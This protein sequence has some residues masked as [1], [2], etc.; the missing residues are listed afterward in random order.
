MDIF[1]NQNILHQNRL[2]PRSTVIPSNVEDTFYYNKEKSDKIIMLTGEY[3]FRYDDGEWG[4]LTVPSMWQF[5]GYG[6]PRY[7]NVDY[8]FPFNP[9]YV[10]NHNH[11]GHYRKKFTVEEKSRRMILHFD[12]VDSA[13]V[14]RINGNYVGMSKGSRLAAEF[15]VAEFIGVGE[16]TIE[17]DVYAL[18]DGSYLEAQDMVLASG[19]FRDVYI[20]CMGAVGLWDYTVKPTLASVTLDLVFDYNA[21]GGYTTAVEIDGQILKKSTTSRMRFDFNIKNPKLWNA[22]TPNLYTLKI[23]VYKGEALVE[24]HSKKIGLREISISNSMLLINGTPVK[25]KGVNRHEYVPDNGR[26]IDYETTKKEL[27]LLKDF[28]CNAIRCSHYPNNPFFYELANEIGIY[29][30]DE[31]D[32]EAHGCVNTGDQGYISKDPAW[33]P[34][35]LDRQKRMYERDKNETCII[36][37]SVGNEA[38]KGENIDKCAEYLHSVE[39]K[40][41]VLY[42]QDDAQ[43]PKV[44][45]FRQVGYDIVASYEMRNHE[46]GTWFKNGMAP[47]IATEY[48]HAMGNSPGLLDKYWECIYKY[49]TMAGGFVWEF[50]NHGVKRGEDYLYG[51]DF[52]ENN[53]ALNFNLDGMCLSDGTPKPSMY[54]LRE[55]FSPAW[56][57]YD[58]GIVIRNTNDFRNLSYL[59]IEWSLLENFRKIDGG[60]VDN[61]NVPA[62][63]FAT[64]DLPY[65][66]PETISSGR[67]YYVNLDFY[68]GE[69]LVSSKQVTLPFAAA[70]KKFIKEKFGYTYE[71]GVIT[72]EDF[73]VKF[74]KGV[75]TKFLY[76]GKDLISSPMAFSFY[77]K[78]IDNDGIKGKRE[79]HISAWQKALLCEYEFFSENE[80]FEIK[81]DELVLKYSG[82]ILPE[83]RFVGFL[84]ELEYHI[85]RGG[86]I[87]VDIKCKPYGAMPEVLPRI[88]V[89]FE[90][91]K[92][93]NKAIWFGRGE[94]ENY[95]DRKFSAKFGLYELSV[96]DMSFHYDR[97]QDNGNRC[98]T[99]F[100]ALAD[101][102]DVGILVVGAEKF[103]FAATDYTMDA[104]VKAEHRSELVKADNNYLY[105]N[106]RTRGIC[107]ASCG[108]EPDYDNELRPHEFEFAFTVM[109][110]TGVEDAERAAEFDYG[111]STKRFS[112]RYSYTPIQMVRENFES[113]D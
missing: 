90:T 95:D 50:K 64:L 4:K 31:C 12:G 96:P 16:N 42:P 58:N 113:K 53:H 41:P 60:R 24:V 92:K 108:P 89:V 67:K 17:I 1:Q 29:V 13:F 77:R 44:T 52:G 30:M 79:K 32:L 82:K 21:D 71:N 91:D 33:L 18:N 25:L 49:H 83:A 36:I 10:G 3:D 23:S 102:S 62:G 27:L 20:I 34:A 51:S 26:A 93:Y 59:T 104:L 88:G 103:S 110:F 19:I 87:T 7:T 47:I 85:C 14:V 69:K 74:E 106:Y 81:E 45:D 54:E 48:A 11:V 73:C 43:D 61:I 22:E 101:D 56:V 107:S 28:N 111:F 75:I 2:E 15:D 5:H 80:S 78:P 40:K 55:V 99:Y 66:L 6:V 68:D 109:P 37:W 105:I 100:A 76:K 70:R 9:P 112:D 57:E 72:A 65:T 98:D 97:P 38:G 94:T 8:I 46:T 35:F 39:I 63:K 84:T 86:K